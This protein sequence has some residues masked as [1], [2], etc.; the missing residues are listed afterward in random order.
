[1]VV[2]YHEWVNPSNVYQ[3]KWLIGKLINETITEV[4]F[5]IKNERQPDFI[6]L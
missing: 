1:M 6:I 2:Y 3:C 5:A 4:Y